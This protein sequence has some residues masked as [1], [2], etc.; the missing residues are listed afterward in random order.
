V[1]RGENQNSKKPSAYMVTES[2]Q[3]KQIK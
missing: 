1:V 2:E 3:N